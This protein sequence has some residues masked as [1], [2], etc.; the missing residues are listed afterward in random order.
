MGTDA[1]II[2]GIGFEDLAQMGVVPADYSVR[3]Y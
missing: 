1:T 2:V 3:Q